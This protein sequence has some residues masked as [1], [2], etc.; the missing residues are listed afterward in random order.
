MDKGAALTSR[1]VYGA[2]AE[3]KLKSLVFSSSAQIN[4][5][6]CCSHLEMWKIE[7]NSSVQKWGVYEVIG[8]WVVRYFVGG[9]TRIRTLWRMSFALHIA[10]QGKKM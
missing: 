3:R 9:N 6:G 1:D 10:Q 8:G 2:K 5:L 4:A 7:Q